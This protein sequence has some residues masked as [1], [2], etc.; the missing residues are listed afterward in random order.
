MENPY[1]LSGSELETYKAIM[2]QLRK[3]W[4]HYPN[5]M[6]HT[7]HLSKFRELSY[8]HGLRWQIFTSTYKCDNQNSQ[9]HVGEI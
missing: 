1:R 4:F 2:S 8:K 3:F 5:P 6:V 7:G 9:I